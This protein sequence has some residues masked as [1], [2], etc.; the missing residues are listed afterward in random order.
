MQRGAAPQPSLPTT[1]QA[2]E[3][4]VLKPVV[5]AAGKT[6]AQ[7]VAWAGPSSVSAAA[8]QTA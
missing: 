6:V 3:K 1:G 5:G 8:R 7:R 2:L 4:L